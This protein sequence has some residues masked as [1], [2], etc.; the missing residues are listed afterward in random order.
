MSEC[1][2]DAKVPVDH[3]LV[4]VPHVSRFTEDMPVTGADAGFET[5]M[6]AIMPPYTPHGDDGQHVCRESIRIAD[7]QWFRIEGSSEREVV[8]RVVR[9]PPGFGLTLNQVIIPP[10]F[11]GHFR[12]DGIT[13]VAAEN[14]GVGI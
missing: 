13:A 8:G 1:I 2:P 11:N 6:R 10:G 9:Y 7:D 5:E 4:S 14:T 3:E 12:H